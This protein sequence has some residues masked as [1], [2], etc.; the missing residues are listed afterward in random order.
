MSKSTNNN[1]RSRQSRLRWVSADDLQVNPVAQREFRLSWAKEI[2][3]S[4]DIDK[5]QIPHV[6][7]RAD[8]DL[9]IMEGQHGTWAYRQ[10]LGENQKVQVWLYEGLTEAEEA[11]FFLSLNNKKSIDSMA[12]FK[13]SVTA[14][15]PDESDVDRI[16]RAAGCQVNNNSAPTSISAVGTLMTIYRRNG[17]ENLAKT[18]KVIADSFVDGG[19]ERPV[20]LGVSMVLARYS[21]I[22]SGKLVRQLAGI[23]N[24]WKGLVQRTALIR[25]QMN[26]TQPEAAAAAVV[27]FYNAGRGSKK[28]PSWWRDFEAVA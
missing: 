10:W 22:D 26:V 7:Q 9:Y 14:G 1:P 6:N 2:L 24:G 25:E 15:R 17:A 28:I 5:F 21:E 8:G 3:A 23:R 19:Y 4:F 12:R 11:E 13:V 20:L 27:E 16:V 18:L